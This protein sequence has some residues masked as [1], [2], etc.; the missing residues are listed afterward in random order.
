MISRVTR[1]QVELASGPGQLVVMHE[2]VTVVRDLLVGPVQAV[3]VD[4]VHQEVPPQLC[5]LKIERGFR[6]VLLFEARRGSALSERGD[7]SGSDRRRL[8]PHDLR[9]TVIGRHADFVFA[10]LRIYQEA[11]TTVA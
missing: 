5:L 1:G 10:V 2:T 8:R 6:W 9:I 11:K 7:G 4:R 3:L